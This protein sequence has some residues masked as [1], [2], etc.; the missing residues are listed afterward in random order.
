[1]PGRADRVL[2]GGTLL[3]RPLGE[4][5]ACAGAAG[6]RGLSLWPHHVAGLPAG[7][8]RRRLA[9]AGL[10]V[11]EVEPL[12]SWL[13]EGSLPPE[14]AGLVGA[15]PEAFFE[16][17]LAVGAPAV[18]AVDGFGA[19]AERPA[20]LE[21]FGR[22]CEDA[23]A[24]GLAVKLEFTPWS[25]IPDARAAWEMVREAGRPD[26]GIVV[27]SW[28]HFRGANDLAMLRALP[29]E[30]VTGVQLNDAPAQPPSEPP[31]VESMHARRLPGE[32][33][34]DLAG[35]LDALDAGGCRAPLGIE[36]FSDALDALP[37]AEVGRRIARAMD[38]LEAARS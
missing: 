35:L 8:V 23:A 6:C 21:A 9:D 25:S 10:A 32:G 29:G 18:V 2:C 4:L 17:A 16:L 26:T 27:D 22:L 20:L 3:R 37:A 30:R 36:V 5:V 11:V 1:M 33:A 24:H 28:H 19:R 13:P 14:T 34:I 7:E 15:P 12:L 38:A 31:A